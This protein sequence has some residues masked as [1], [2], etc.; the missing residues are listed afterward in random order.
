[1]LL[2]ARWRRYKNKFWN[3]AIRERN[4]RLWLNSVQNALTMLWTD[5]IQPTTCHE[6]ATSWVRWRLPVLQLR[7]HAESGPP[8][9]RDG[10]H[11]RD[12]YDDPPGTEDGHVFG[13]GL[14][15]TSYGSSPFLTATQSRWNRALVSRRR[16][17]VERKQQRR[18]RGQGR[19]SMRPLWPASGDSPHNCNTMSK[20]HPE[21]YRHIFRL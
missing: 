8:D 9:V 12:A 10:P 13:V 1:M 19:D 5:K 6:Q 17:H 14:W 3:I 16:E 7:F 11:E 2:H 4:L 21:R 20:K 18:C 15:A